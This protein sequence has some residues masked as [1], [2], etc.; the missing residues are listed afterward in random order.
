MATEAT[1]SGAIALI[2][3]DVSRVDVPSLRFLA[4]LAARIS[5]LPIALVVAAR[6]G[7]PATDPPAL[8][9]LRH[10]AGELVLRPQR[11]SPEGV[12]QLV[13]AAVPD[14]AVGVVEMCEQMTNGNPF[15]LTALLEEMRAMNTGGVDTP[16]DLVAVVGERLH[17]EQK[18]RGV[19]VSAML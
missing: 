1:R 11:L 18:R 19:H 8:A 17:V 5:P 9:A 13:Q 6:G 10:A 12:R 15:L 7:E 3:D 4:Y 14:V 2:L 16:P